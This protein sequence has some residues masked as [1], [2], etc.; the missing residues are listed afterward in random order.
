ML[1]WTYLLTV[2]G[3]LC[4]LNACKSKDSSQN[5]NTIQQTESKNF[6]QSYPLLSAFV[7][8]KPEVKEAFEKLVLALDQPIESEA[9]LMEVVEMRDS[10]AAKLGAPV[11]EL[12]DAPLEEVQQ[13]ENEAKTLGVSFMYAEGMP[14]NAVGTT[15]ILEV[16]AKVASE[17][18]ALV[19]K[20]RHA[21]NDA[22]GGEYPYADLSQYAVALD[23]AEQLMAKYP[24]SK[25]IEDILDIYLRLLGIFTDV[26][27]AEGGADN[28]AIV[29]GIT[30]DPYPGMSDL[31]FN[32]EYAAKHPNTL[33][34]KLISKVLENVS[35]VKAT[36]DGQISDIY[37]VK[38]DEISF[39]NSDKYVAA[40][41]LSQGVDVPHLIWMDGAVWVVYRFYSDSVKAAKQLPKILPKTGKAIVAKVPAS[42]TANAY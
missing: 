11:S 2:L 1:K 36:E 12:H 27:I 5:E 34:G 42:A 6:A 8:D 31:K 39:D 33:A 30:L 16:V 25:Y 9:R 26:H 19:L 28:S 10:L 20:T 3:I 32:R 41:Y 37:A 4:Q 17:P 14:L 40:K 24:K 29:G 23:L 18:Y 21:F 38:I 13:L 7:A 22:L 15:F 35:E